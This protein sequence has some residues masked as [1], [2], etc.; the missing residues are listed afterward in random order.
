[1]QVIPKYCANL[2][3]DV[4]LQYKNAANRNGFT[5][6]ILFVEIDKTQYSVSP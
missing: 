1:M 6:F 3:L 5:A 4:F 2:L